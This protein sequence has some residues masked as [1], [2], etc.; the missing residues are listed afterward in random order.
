MRL[1]LEENEI[2]W[3]FIASAKY[4][5]HVSFTYFQY[6]YFSEQKTDYPLNRAD[7]PAT[8]TGLQNPSV[9]RIAHLLIP[10]QCTLASHEN[11]FQIQLNKETG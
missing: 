10:K 6:Y 2:Y 5:K 8:A 1:S 9:Q 11:S 7:L 4:T 3:Y